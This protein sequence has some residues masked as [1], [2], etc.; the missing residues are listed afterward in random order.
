MASV[1]SR[2]RALE[3]RMVFYR[4]QE[5]VEFIAEGFVKQWGRGLNWDLEPPRTE[6]FAMRL[7]REGFTPPGIN[8]ALRYL[9]ECRD[10]GDVP[11]Y[12]TLVSK[13]LP[14]RSRCP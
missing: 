8:A 14:R 3:R 11:E 2:V 12:R 1:K 7:R 10:A 9:N 5:R 13:A 4:A 6:E